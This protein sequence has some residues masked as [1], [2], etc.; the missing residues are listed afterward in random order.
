MHLQVVHCPTTSADRE[1]MLV[2]R[3]DCRSAAS[4]P[5]RGTPALA[6]EALGECIDESSS[7]GDSHSTRS[8]CGAGSKKRKRHACADGG[9]RADAWWGSV[10]PH[11]LPPP[12]CAHTGVPSHHK[13]PMRSLSVLC[14]CGLRSAW[15]QGHRPVLYASPRCPYAVFMVF[16]P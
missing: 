15:R 10:L 11:V 6:G 13:V 5:K 9:A 16:P 3:R 8:S 2:L 7:E 14:L 1:A 12:T 4:T